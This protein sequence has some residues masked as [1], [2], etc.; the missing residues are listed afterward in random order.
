[1]Y[2]PNGLISGIVNRF[3]PNK[4]FIGAQRTYFKDVVFPYQGYC[5]NFYED[6]NIEAEGWMIF[7]E[8]YLIDCEEVGIWKYYNAD[9]KIRIV[10]YSKK[11]VTQARHCNA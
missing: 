1:M 3:F 8:N 7:T 5:Y 10:D 9:G 4:D 2:Y 6:G 11:D